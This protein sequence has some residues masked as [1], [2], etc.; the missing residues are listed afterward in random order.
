M[1]ASDVCLDDYLV[2]YNIDEEEEEDEG[3]TSDVEMMTV[4]YVVLTLC[5]LGRLLVVR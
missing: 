4:V 5:R 1:H 2:G 3:G